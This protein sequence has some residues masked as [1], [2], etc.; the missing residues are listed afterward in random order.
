M[1]ETE[2]RKLFKLNK[3]L[4]VLEHCFGRIPVPMSVMLERVAERELD[5]HLYHFRRLGVVRV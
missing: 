3:V 5:F 1:S 2:R 4:A